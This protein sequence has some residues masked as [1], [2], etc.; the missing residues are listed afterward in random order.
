[1]YNSKI[2]GLGKF[3]P[4][5]IVTNNDLEKTMETSNEWIIERTGI[6]ERRHIKKGDNE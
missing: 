2:I 1:M 6:E 4:E 3:L 5:N